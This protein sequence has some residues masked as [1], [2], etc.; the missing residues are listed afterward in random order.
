MIGIGKFIKEMIAALPSEVWTGL[1]AVAVWALTTLTN[2]MSNSH[3]RK[4]LKVQLDHDSEERQRERK[5]A[6]KREVL[7]PALDAG[8][9]SM[10]LIAMLA[11]PDVNQAK[12]DDGLMAASQKLVK[13]CAM[14]SA[15]TWEVIGRLQHALWQLQND[16]LYRRL[17][18][19]SASAAASYAREQ[20]QVAVEE[21][22][23]ANSEQRQVHGKRGYALS[24]YEKIGRVLAVSNEYLNAMSAREREAALEL[25]T[26]QIEMLEALE[27]RYPHLN[28][29]NI[30]AVL[31]L[32][33][34]LGFEANDHEIKET[35]KRLFVEH[36]KIVDDMLDRL[37]KLRADL[38]RQ[39]KQG[40]PGTQ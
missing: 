10:S 34:E 4:L 20:A 14:C 30:D 1:G 40:A 25:L 36:Q 2:R 31:A 22:E 29:L 38:E 15:E 33:M 17:P 24:D 26:V 39:L 35:R 18:L 11:S 27:E 37:R 16:M 19:L 21:M 23:R 28:T 7:M 3:A 12:V 8:A 32:R 5:A 13:A 9:Q 6:M